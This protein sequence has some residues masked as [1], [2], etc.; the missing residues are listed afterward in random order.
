VGQFDLREPTG[1]QEP[2]VIGDDTNATPARFQQRQYGIP[3]P[4]YLVIQLLRKVFSQFMA[5][6]V[7]AANLDPSSGTVKGHSNLVSI[8]QFYLPSR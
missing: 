7:D 5:K 8:E 3:N 4:I 6:L 1:H 2:A